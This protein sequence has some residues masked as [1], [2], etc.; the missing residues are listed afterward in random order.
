MPYRT[1]HGLVGEVGLVEGVL[2]RCVV[3]VGVESERCQIR[4]YRSAS[5]R[6][7]SAGAAGIDVLVS[8]VVVG[9]DRP[10]PD[11]QSVT[12]IVL[13]DGHAGLYVDMG[14]VVERTA[15]ETRQIAI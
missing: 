4:C 3:L 8:P 14:V 13:D 6:G 1:C 11:G 7:G 15:E 12:E 5:E 2:A 10:V 9:V